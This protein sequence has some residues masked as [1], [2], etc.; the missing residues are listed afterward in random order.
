MFKEK[1]FFFFFK[2]LDFFGLKEMEKK[3]FFFSIF[4]KDI[5][6]EKAFFFGKK[7]LNEKLFFFFQI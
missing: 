6:E 1:N 4:G 5:F 3:K 7:G 2:I